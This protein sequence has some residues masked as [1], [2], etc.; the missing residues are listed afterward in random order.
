MSKRALA[1]GIAFG[2]MA[3]LAGGQ[4]AL[5]GRGRHKGGESPSRGSGGAAVKS[6]EFRHGAPV[7]P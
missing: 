7:H 2:L 1:A 5:A 6:V 3:T 4:A